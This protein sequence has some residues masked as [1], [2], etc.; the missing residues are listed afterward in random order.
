M[1]FFSIFLAL[2][3]AVLTTV[4]CDATCGELTEVEAH[5][6]TPDE[7]GD[8]SGADNCSPFCVCNC[9]QTNFVLLESDR[10]IANHGSTLIHLNKNEAIH[11]LSSFDLWRPPKA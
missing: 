2:L 3:V 8:H 11:S 5:F 1:K 9:C 7:H 6:H 4:P 10:S